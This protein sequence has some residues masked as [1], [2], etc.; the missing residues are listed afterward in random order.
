[1]K[2][3]VDEMPERPEECL[4]CE[5]V[6]DGIGSIA[7]PSDYIC[8]LG[9]GGNFRCNTQCVIYEEAYPHWDKCP[10]LEVK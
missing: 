8:K 4:F 5:A 7:F 2:I 1:M 6:Y 3:L 9:T 10:K